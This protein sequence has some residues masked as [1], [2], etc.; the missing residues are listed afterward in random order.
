MSYVTNLTI[1]DLRCNGTRPAQATLMDMIVEHITAAQIEACTGGTLIRGPRSL[2]FS[3]VS[4]D[5]RTLRAGDL[6]FAIRGRNNDGH[7]F[8][9]Q[10]LDRGAAGVVVDRR[11]DPPHDFPAGRVLLQVPDTHRALEDLAAEIRRRWQGSLVAVTGSMGKTTTKEFAYQ[12]LRTEFSVYRSAGNLNNLFGLPLALL[13]LSSEDHIG[14]FEMGMSAAGEIREM[15]TVARPDVGVILN[16]AP[17]HLEFFASLEEIARAKGELAEG[18]RPGGTLVYNAGDPLV[19]DIAAR[20]PGSRISFGLCAAAD[21]RADEIEVLGLEETRF[22]LTCGGLQWSASIP[23]GGAHYVVNALA[24]VALA[25]H[26]RM[27]TEQI[28]EALRALQPVGMR[29]PV[30]RFE[31]GITVIDDSYNSNPRALCRMI[32]ALAQIRSCTRR[33]LVAGEML[34]LGPTSGALHHECGVFAAERGIDLVVGVQGAAREIVRGALQAGLPEAAAWFFS[35]GEPAADFLVRQ[36]RAGDLV[37]I[38]GSRG[39][40]LERIVAHL[41]STFTPQAA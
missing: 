20:F 22:R 36:L 2:V 25:R 13:G 15:C 10:A 3:G 12:V 11:Q 8:I 33:I 39:V 17:V 21:V 16:V 14:I 1:H 41:Q 27:D 4:I 5:S 30:L 6:F 7:R 35:A 9:G 28:L 18:L 26:Y 37:L 19:S 31:E 23:L 32:E 40:H 38:K 29:G 34:E 24:A